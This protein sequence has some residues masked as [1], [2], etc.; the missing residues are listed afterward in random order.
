MPVSGERG[1]VAGPHGRVP[2]RQAREQRGHSVL[3]PADARA[4][5]VAEPEPVV[6]EHRGDRVLEQPTVQQPGQRVRGAPVRGRRGVHVIV[7]ERVQPEHGEVRVAA[8]KPREVLSVAEHAVGR[9][10][11]TQAEGHAAVPGHGQ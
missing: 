8:V 5:S 4:A 7:A 1:A 6:A 2:R 3:E 9:G 11:R 10:P